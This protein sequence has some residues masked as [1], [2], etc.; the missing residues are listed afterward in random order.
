MSVTV[1]LPVQFRESKE[2]NPRLQLSRIT[3]LWALSESALGGF[4]HAVKIPFR[5]M[6]IS[7]VAVFLIGLFGYFRK[8][9]DSI[10]KES[11]KVTMIKA[12][13][14]PHTP[15]TAYIAV[16][17]QGGIGGGFFIG[18]K[19]FRLRMYFFSFIISILTGM[20]RFLIL[21]LI[22]GESLW[23]SINDLFNYAL[24]ALFIPQNSFEINFSF[25]II[26]LYVGVHVLG[27]IITAWYTNITVIT[28]SDQTITKLIFLLQPDQIKNVNNGYIKK[29][30]IPITIIIIL[31][32][33]GIVIISYI[34]SESK[35][36]DVSSLLF[37]IIRSIIILLFWFYV[38]SPLVAS[39]LQKYFSRKRKV[40]SSDLNKI[41]EILPSL[42]LTVINLWKQSS[43]IKG[44]R[45]LD[46][47]IKY[48]LLQ[49]IFTDEGLT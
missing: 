47:L 12:L 38:L 15:L 27:G 23:R 42:K 30:S 28:L 43:N 6:I 37:M 36:F 35:G 9:S 48:L 2:N 13:I 19:F 49:I 21:T 25:W 22:F 24:K 5:G 29:K 18:K 26:S 46:Y 14:S 39:L 10:V 11:V 34:L 20:Q 32:A 3:A 1:Q 31:A 44:L 41:N 16:L 17:M 45:R 40:Y 8:K 4:L 7:N 33:I